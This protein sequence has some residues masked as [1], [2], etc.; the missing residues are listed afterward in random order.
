MPNSSSFAEEVRRLRLSGSEKMM[1]FD[2]VSLFTK[3]PVQEAVEVVCKLTMTRYLRGVNWE[4]T[5]F[6]N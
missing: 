3:V 2:V 1:S 4:W 5:L 6:E